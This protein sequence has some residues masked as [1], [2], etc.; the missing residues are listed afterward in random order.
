MIKL[1]FL[2]LLLSF[3]SLYAEEPQKVLTIYYGIDSGKAHC[4]DKLKVPVLQEENHVVKLSSIWATFDLDCISP[5]RLTVVGIEDT[6]MNFTTR[7]LKSTYFISSI[8]RWK[9]CTLTTSD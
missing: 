9:T 7:E 8:R 3:Y 4:Y 5:E 2:L 1:L 6:E